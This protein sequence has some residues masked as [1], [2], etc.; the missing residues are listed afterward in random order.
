MARY[1]GKVGFVRTVEVEP[2]VWE[3]EDTVREY[4]G[5]VISNARRWSAKSNSTNDDLAM[6]NQISIIAD[7]FILDNSGAI[8]W[9]EYCGARWKVTNVNIAAPRIELTLGSVYSDSLEADGDD[10]A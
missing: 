1:F 9:A 3:P 7:S 4:F 2:G 10:D 6:N 5:D 8:K